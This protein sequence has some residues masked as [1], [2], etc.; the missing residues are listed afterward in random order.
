MRKGLDPKG[1]KEETAEKDNFPELPRIKTPKGLCKDRCK[2][3]DSPEGARQATTP[4]SP[5][6]SSPPLRCASSP[7]IN[8]NPDS[9]TPPPTNLP[10]NTALSLALDSTSS[11]TFSDLPYGSFGGYTCGRQLSKVRRFLG[12]LVQF[13]NDISADV[14]ERVK[15]LVLNLVSSSL[16]IEDFHHSLQD[17]TNFPLRPFV[18]PFLKAHIP[19]LQREIHALARLNKQPSLQYVRTHDHVILE[20]THSP[21]EPSEIFMP[22]NEGHLTNGVKR[23]SPEGPYENGL[24]GSQLEDYPTAN[25]RPFI[26]NNHQQTFLNP[27]NTHV[28]DYQPPGPTPIKMEE[29]PLNTKGDEEWRNIHVMLN[30]ILSM[31]EKTK[32]ALTILQQ[33]NAS[34]QPDPAT[35]WLRK[36]DVSQDLKKVANEIIST[37][38][39]AAEERVAEVRRRAEEAVVDVKRQAVMELQR[40]VAAAEARAGELLAVERAR[41][42]KALGEARKQTDESTSGEFAEGAQSPSSQPAPSQQN[43][44][45][46]CGRKANDTCSGCSLARYCGPFCQHKDWENHHQVCNKEK[47]PTSLAPTVPTQLTVVAPPVADTR[48]KK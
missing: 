14:G 28:F 25:K 33:R 20:P 38:I 35:D 9:V 26:F 5:S 36:Q 27:T 43:A 34:T 29:H 39:R 1:I 16:N 3:P 45:W 10:S 37:A 22:V 44:C 46:N 48:T 17:V 6:Q 23:R 12:T 18:L 47:R 41:V 2:T 21:S 32:R 7:V 4:L 42:E 24:N 40:A 19:M 13:G 8:S 31:V 15:N 30:C 11:R